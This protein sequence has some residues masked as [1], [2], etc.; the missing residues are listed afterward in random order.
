MKQTAV[1]ILIVVLVLYGCYACV[2]VLTAPRN[3]VSHH[4]ASQQ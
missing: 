2:S 4:G 3:Y 1:S